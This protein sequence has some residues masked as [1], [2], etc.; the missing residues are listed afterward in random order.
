MKHILV[1]G[2][3]ITHIPMLDKPPRIM[4]STDMGSNYVYGLSMIDGRNIFHVLVSFF[5]L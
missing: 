2:V 3:P 4:D 5:H 1:L